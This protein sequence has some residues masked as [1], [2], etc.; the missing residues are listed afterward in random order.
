MMNEKIRRILDRLNLFR[1]LTDVEVAQLTIL[2]RSD[3]S[4]KRVGVIMDRFDEQTAKIDNSLRRMESNVV[5]FEEKVANI[6][7]IELV[8]HELV[9]LKPS[10]DLDMVADLNR[11]I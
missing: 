3:D 7:R 11:V 4:L 6:E 5:L 10:V 9:S 8:L 2:K 1:R